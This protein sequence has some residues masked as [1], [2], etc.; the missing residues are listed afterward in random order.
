[1]RLHQYRVLRPIWLYGRVAA[2]GE[3]LRLPEQEAAPLVE[4]G[5]IRPLDVPLADAASVA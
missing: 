4:S 3:L 1:M 5:H 2:S